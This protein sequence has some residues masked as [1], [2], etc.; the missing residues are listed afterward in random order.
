MMAIS[1]V[2]ESHHN[3]H[4]SPSPP[5]VI[6]III[7]LLSLPL[8]AASNYGSRHNVSIPHQISVQ[9]FQISAA[10]SQHQTIPN[11]PRHKGPNAKKSRIVIGLSS[12]ALHCTYVL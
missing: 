2:Y 5:P 8:H 6:R 10:C 11:A 9:Q 12:I 1:Y 7:Y 4:K 3:Y